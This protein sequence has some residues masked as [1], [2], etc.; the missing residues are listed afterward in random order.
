MV[1][2]EHLLNQK[3]KSDYRNKYTIAAFYIHKSGDNKEIKL[4]VPSF[5]RQSSPLIWNLE[6]HVHQ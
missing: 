3:L 5:V 6:G 4:V 1:C 2:K